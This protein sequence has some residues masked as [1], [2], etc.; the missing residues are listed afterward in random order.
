MLLC[1]RSCAS[2]T[3]PPSQLV[4]RCA[5]RTR[6]EAQQSAWRVSGVH[7]HWKMFL[8]FPNFL[9]QTHT[10]TEAEKKHYQ[11]GT[12]LEDQA[13]PA[14]RGWALAGWPPIL[15][16]LPYLPGGERQDSVPQAVPQCRA[17]PRLRHGPPLEPT[18]PPLGGSGEARG[19]EEAP[20]K[21]RWADTGGRGLQDRPR[22]GARGTGTAL[23]LR[24][25]PGGQTGW[26]GQGSHTSTD[27]A[28]AQNRAARR[29][30]TQTTG[31]VTWMRSGKWPVFGLCYSK[32]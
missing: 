17:R 25:Q 15:S 27:R 31:Q 24:R 5:R 3:P 20:R 11:A 12:L 9:Q 21:T 7:F 28:A 19:R 32:T 18:P 8:Y 13:R 22:S 6:I 14:P 4:R 16:G 26:A 10:L 29:A 1:G 30:H 23:S 2:E